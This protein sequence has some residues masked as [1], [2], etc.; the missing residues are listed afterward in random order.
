VVLRAS[1]VQAA[2][3]TGG[4]ISLSDSRPSETS[5]EYDSDW[6]NVTTSAIQC[7]QIQFCDA[8][9]CSGSIPTDMD[10]TGGSL[11]T[12]NTDYVP[13]PGDWTTD[14]TTTNGTVQITYGTGET[15]ASSSDRTIAL[16]GIDNGSTA[17]TGYYVKINT[18]N[19]TDCSTSPVDDGVISYIYTSGQ[20]V[21]M[22]VDPSISFSLSSVAASES[23]NSATTTETSTTSTIPL[24]TVTDST[25]GIAAHDLTVTTNAENGYTVYARYTAKPTYSSATI[26]DISGTNDSPASFPSPGTEGFGYTTE[27]TSLSVTGDGADRFGSNEWAKFTTS[28][29]E[30]AYNS[31]AA[32]SETTRVGYQAG[33]SST[34]EAGSYTT[35]VILTCTP[36]Y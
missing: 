19:D 27:D 6:D 20:S 28:N 24:G 2:T 16:D 9:D 1:T 12:S 3:L 23:V 32:S 14:F 31:A 13:T 15:P 34:T 29:A 22:T 10:T 25:N 8:A 36:T 21:S 35:T 30:M 7:I 5:V 33:I 18:Y 17:D 11:D 4:S 26:D